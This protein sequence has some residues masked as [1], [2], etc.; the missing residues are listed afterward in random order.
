[1]YVPAGRP[2]IAIL[3]PEPVVV[4]LPGL[5]VTVQVP[6]AGSPFITILP[7]ATEQVGWVM[8]PMAGATDIGE[9]VTCVVAVVTPQPPEAE[10]V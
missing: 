2:E 7:V 10:I 3:V 8:F 5:R 1:V 9:I 6:V 4:I